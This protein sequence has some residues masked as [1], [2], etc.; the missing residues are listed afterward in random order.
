MKEPKRILVLYTELAGYL[1]ACF[2]EAQAQG[3]QL[4]VLHWPVNDEA[5]FELT[6]RAGI[7]FIEREGKGAKQ[8][9]ELLQKVD[10]DVVL[11]SGWIDKGYLKAL[12]KWRKACP[13]V[14]AMDTAWDASV[15]QRLLTGLG[16]SVLR[17]CFSHAWVAGEGQ[18]AY[19]IK[20]GFDAAKIKTGFYSADA[21]LFEEIYQA[22]QQRVEPEPTFLYVGRYIERK[23]LND[24]W[25]AFIQAKKEFPSDWRL[26]CAGTGEDFDQRFIHEDIIH[27]GFKQP[28]ELKHVIRD[29]NAFVLPSHFEPWGVVVHEMVQAGLPIIL[30]DQIGS[31]EQFLIDGKNGY[32]FQAGNVSQLKDRLLMMM[33]ASIDEIQAMSAISH[34]MA[35]KSTPAFWV[36]TLEGFM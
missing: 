20:L 13:T 15:K 1:L 6:E 3:H 25:A 33:R 14:L 30:S 36:E 12:A 24:L 29:A 23:G 32:S 22:R 34:D 16:G 35:L 5:P 26:V 7:E 2:S 17:R 21:K 9:M 27:L 8:V 4:T 19:A 18:K 11:C 10:P 28:N 31:K